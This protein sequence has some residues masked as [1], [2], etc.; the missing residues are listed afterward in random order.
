MLKNLKSKKQVQLLVNLMIKKNNFNKLEL[1][2]TKP[3]QVQLWINLNNRKENKNK[4][5]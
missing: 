5:V 2:T 3:K 1:K 4:Q